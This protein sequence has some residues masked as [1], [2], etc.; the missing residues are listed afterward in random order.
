MDAFNLPAPQAAPPVQRFQRI[1]RWRWNE[2]REKLAYRYFC[3]RFG[4]LLNLPW[5][6]HYAQGLLCLS[7]ADNACNAGEKMTL[8]G[9]GIRPII[10]CACAYL[11]AECRKELL[12]MHNSRQ[13]Q[14]PVVR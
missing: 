12:A 11:H 9:D 7:S 4:P 5:Q 3:W 2:L 8:Q 14:E 1:Q 13:V 6:V 10:S